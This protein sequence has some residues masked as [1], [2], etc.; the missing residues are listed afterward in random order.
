MA[1]CTVT[2]NTATAITCSDGLK[3]EGNNPQSWENGDFYGIKGDGRGATYFQCY[4]NAGELCDRD[5]SGNTVSNN[6]IDYYG[7]SPLFFFGQ[8]HLTVY[9]NSVTGYPAT[10]HSQGLTHYYSTG[11][12]NIYK[13]YFNGIRSAMAFEGLSGVGNGG[14]NIHDNIIY[15]SE[16]VYPMVCWGPPGITGTVWLNSNT[17]V[18]PNLTHP[19]SIYWGTCTNTLI[20]KNNILNGEISLD[21]PLTSDHN[22]Y[23][24]TDSGSE[25]GSVYHTN[26]TDIFQGTSFSSAS[27]FKLKSTSPAKDSGVSVVAYGVSTDYS[28]I[29][30]PQ[31]SGWD[32][33]A[34]EYSSGG[35]DTTV[36]SAPSGLSVQ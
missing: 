24:H 32:I 2:S 7:D 31:G 23:T 9:G 27:D 6:V 5:S 30:R 16:D 26:L 33:G 12:A 28:G 20:A 25:S 36:P 17:I 8:D 19:I 29:T 21:G 13:N 11:R 3:D 10:P 34:Y 22:C 15:V 18:A 35:G 14:L 4:A 1:H